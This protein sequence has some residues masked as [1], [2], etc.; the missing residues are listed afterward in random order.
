M[1]CFV[2]FLI[3]TTQILAKY[4][5]QTTDSER[6]FSKNTYSRRICVKTQHAAA[7]FTSSRPAIL[8]LSAENRAASINELTRK[9]F[10]NIPARR[11]IQN[12]KSY[13]IH[14]CMHKK[15]H[16]YLFDD[17]LFCKSIHN[18]LKSRQCS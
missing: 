1:F 13:S 14:A 8:I 15:I 10:K 6:K 4:S 18:V 17:Q 2:L 11:Y 9:F 5:L 3:M 7:I 16:Q 12:L